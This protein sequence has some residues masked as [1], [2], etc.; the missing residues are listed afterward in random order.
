MF[1][2]KKE[3]YRIKSDFPEYLDEILSAY[4]A[5]DLET[6]LDEIRGKLF[7]AYLRTNLKKRKTPKQPRCP[8]CCGCGGCDG[9]GLER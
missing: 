9:P 3:L 5:E 8:H 4:A 6:L 7:F 1:D 2:H